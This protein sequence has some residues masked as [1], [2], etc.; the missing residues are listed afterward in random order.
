MLSAGIVFLFASYSSAANFL[1]KAALSSA[2]RARYRALS[3]WY[4][5]SSLAILSSSSLNFLWRSSIS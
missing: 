1:A 5:A 4:S 2:L 3:F